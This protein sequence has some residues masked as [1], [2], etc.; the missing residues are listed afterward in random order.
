MRLH[1][2]NSGRPSPSPSRTLPQPIRI[3]AL[4][5]APLLAL[6]ALGACDGDDGNGG[7]G[8][9][10]ASTNSTG[11]STSV[12]GGAAAGGQG[13]GGGIGGEGGGGPQVACPTT[14]VFRPTGSVSNPRVVGEWHAFN[15]ATATPMQGPTGDGSYRASV[16]LL[17]GLYA[18]KFIYDG[19][20]ELVWVLDDGQGRRKYYGDTE[21][22]AV[23]VR[24]C[25][26]PSL[27]V[28]SSVA[29][30][31]SEGQGTYQATLAYHDGI[32][33]A[34]PDPEGFET[35]LWRDQTSEP[36]AT[37]DATVDGAGN[38]TLELT[39]LDDG[40]YRVV[41]RA[42][43]L[44]G[45]H[46][47][48]LRLVF[49]IEAEQFAWQ[50]ALIYM[51]V[52]DRYRNGSSANDPPETSGADPRGDWFGGDLEGVRQSIA[53][54]LLDEL[55]V[56]ALWL[57]PFNT[58][59]VGAYLASDG[60][61]QVAP[62]HGYWPIRA[63]EVDAR[64]GGADALRALVAEAHAHGI[65][66]LQDLVVNH[67]HEDHEYVSAHPEWFRT[68][69]VCGG[70][71]CDWTPHALDCM[72]AD[73]LP[74]VNHSV[75][76][77]NQAFVADAVWWLDEFD[78]D[79]LR[80]DAVKHVEEAA[81]RNIAAS[82]R[83]TFE[84]SGNEV[85]LMGE[86]AMGWSDGMSCSS[87]DY[88]TIARYIGP[89]GLDGQFDF[90][91]YHGVSYRTFAY[92]WNGMIHADYWT[93]YGL[94]CWPE[95]AIMTPYIG[96][97]DT[98]RFVS[99]ADYRGGASHGDVGIPGNQ[100]T[101]TAEAPLDPEP[102]RRARIALGWLLTLPGAPL[103]Y[104]GDEYGQWGGA[105]PNNRARWRVEASLDSDEQATLDFVRA[106]GTAR[107]ELAALRRGA[108]RSLGSTEDTLVFARAVPSGPVAVVGITRAT[109]DQPMTVDASTVGL[110]QGTVLHDA[111]GGPDVTVGSGGSL[112]LSVPASGAVILAP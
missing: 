111:L 19:T 36:L 1:S 15:T 7:A 50:D 87:Q 20:S 12:G 34:G 35:T 5:L 57:T 61:H 25:R 97:H 65:R 83:E 103:L 45:R 74:D 48:P 72:F 16:D 40:K 13:A 33:A 54:G 93:S 95:G 71:D 49:W 44:T 84:P 17:P 88:Q 18:Y 106:V 23:L 69:C 105:D 81:I 22:S 52:T 82:V 62:Y 51:V 32:E 101:N 53:E 42:R 63:R 108:Y 107:R 11:A 98:A 46:S 92:S 27:T 37:P 96:S 59:P 21:N 104:Y 58:N 99:L 70:P 28:E 110:T 6:A 4:L 24:D 14:F 80:V 75:T 94:G 68:G 73:Y 89:F 55:G 109:T 3:G 56:R 41:V 67:V 64:L 90:V 112:T 10:G 100:W 29:A 85:F 66:V 60:V 77:A 39:G 8:G 30:R 76:E 86:T 31:P 79:G 102:Y 2:R 43:T 47:E 26:L 91:L 9:A 78:L 38:V